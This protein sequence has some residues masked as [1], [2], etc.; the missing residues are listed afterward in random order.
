MVTTVL[1]VIGIYCA[2]IA[3]ICVALKRACR[4][5]PKKGEAK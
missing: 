3:I 4:K 1:T 5:M 2:C